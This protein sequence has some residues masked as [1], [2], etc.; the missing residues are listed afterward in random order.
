MTHPDQGHLVA[1][2]IVGG[3]SS[4]A[5]LAYG[6]PAWTVCP[7]RLNVGRAASSIATSPRL[8]A[9]L[10][11]G[12]DPMRELVGT[13]LCRK[14]CNGRRHGP[15]DPELRRPRWKS[16]RRREVGGRHVEGASGS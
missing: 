15:T 9:S 4:A 12:S 1:R 7:T 3:A 2:A 16:S 8:S 11:R 14:S 6:C 13:P 5:A 10:T